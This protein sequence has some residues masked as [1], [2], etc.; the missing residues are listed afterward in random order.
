MNAPH[1]LFLSRL[2]DVRPSGRG[3]IA[4][5]PA[6]QDKTASLSIAVGDDGRVLLHDFGGCDV[7]AIVAAVGLEIGDLFPQRQRDYSEAGRA[8]ARAAFRQ[9]GWV[10][11]LNVL[12]LESKIVVI[13]GR[14]IKRRQQLS[15][16]DER[17]LD[18]A[19]NRIDS[20][21]EVLNGR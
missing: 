3:H 18:E 14:Q 4:R 11:A 12:G 17:R 5:C 6:H 21:R 20:A 7:A 15:D 16:E 19:L 1:E 13:A 8:Q 2:G 9:S 10:A